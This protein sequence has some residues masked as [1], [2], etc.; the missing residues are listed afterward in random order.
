MSQ[1]HK[2]PSLTFL[3]LGVVLAAI[4]TSS[5]RTDKNDSAV[6]IFGEAQSKIISREAVLAPPPPNPKQDLR[7]TVTVA[8]SYDS[9]TRL[10]TYAYAVENQHNSGNALDTWGVAPVRDPITLGAPAHWDGVNRWQERLDSVV[11]TVVDD[12]GSQSR[13]TTTQTLDVHLSPHCPQ[14]GTTISGFTF[15]SRQP[16]TTVNFYAQGFDTLLDVAHDAGE[17]LPLRN[18]LFTNGVTGTTLGPDIT[19]LVS[20]GGTSDPSQGIEFHPPTPNHSAHDLSVT[21]YLPTSAV[22][23]LAVHDLS[24]RRVRVLAEGERLAGLHSV[25]WNGTDEKGHRVG[26]GVYFT[27]LMVGGERVGQQKITILR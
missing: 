11:W 6:P 4:L 2:V 10:Y 21:Y 15:T 27:R 17:S 25:S 8:V 1:P 7:I 3:T 18:T 12:V 26:S 19:S 9:T 5:G 13:D 14:P 22:V 24:G 20:V 16:P 23:Q